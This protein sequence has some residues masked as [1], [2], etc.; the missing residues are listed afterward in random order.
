M[1]RKQWELRVWIVTVVGKSLYQIIEE[2]E[3]V[4]RHQSREMT[5]CG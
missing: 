3:D 5:Q 4:T 2:P 1:S